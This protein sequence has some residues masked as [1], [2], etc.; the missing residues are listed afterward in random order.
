[1]TERELKF[2]RSDQHVPS[3]AEL[4]PALEAEGLSLGAASRVVHED[5]YYDDARLSLSRAGLALRQR[6]AQGRVL[7]ALKEAGRVQGAL[8]RRDELELP[9]PEDA[10][11]QD[12]WPEAIAERIR[13]VTDPRSLK[14]LFRLRTERV[15]FPV[16]QGETPVAEL[17]FDAVEARRTHGERSAHFDELE[18]E[19]AGEEEIEGDDPLERIARAL[20]TLMPLVPSSHTKLERA[21]ALL[22]IDVGDDDRA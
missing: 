10:T 20:E 12:P 13:T 7:A 11:A 15:R 17:A 8:H 18:V 14:P 3:A 1:M 9:V 6:M 4:A 19:A 22:M 16:L 21:R 5:R 2:S